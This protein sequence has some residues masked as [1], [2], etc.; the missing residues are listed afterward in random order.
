MDATFTALDRCGILN[1][2]RMAR[3]AAPA[4]GH[5]IALG[6]AETKSC[7]A[8]ARRFPRR[9]VTSNAP[10]A[11]CLIRTMRA[12]KIDPIEAREAELKRAQE[13]A[14]RAVTFSR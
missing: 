6:L 1:K 9:W 14:A 10:V 13:K 11:C 12:N 5:A 4:G 7:L 2:W 8:V 3:I